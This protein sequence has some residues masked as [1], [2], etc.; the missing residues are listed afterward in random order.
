MSALSGFVSIAGPE[1]KDPKTLSWVFQSWGG[2]HRFLTWLLKYSSSRWDT[3]SFQ[4]MVFLQLP[5]FF[6]PYFKP[7]KGLI[8]V[9][10]LKIMLCWK[11]SDMS[12]SGQ[13][14]PMFF[15]CKLAVSFR[16]GFLKERD[17]P[18]NPYLFQH[19]I[20]IK[21]SSKK[22]WLMQLFSTPTNLFAT[23]TARKS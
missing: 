1:I 23:R 11:M 8:W 3:L 13:V 19:I 12:F 21:S 15:R 4:V 14:R 6:G 2:F 10:I 7:F 16:E 5:V 22:N 18:K 17:P 20:S 9:Y